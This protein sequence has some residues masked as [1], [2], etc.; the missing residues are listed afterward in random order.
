MVI[1]FVGGIF[2]AVAAGVFG[3]IY[4]LNKKNNPPKPPIIE[5]NDE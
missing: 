2:V 3:L 1:L 4:Y 5:M